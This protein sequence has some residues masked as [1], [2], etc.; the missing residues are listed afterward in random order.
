MRYSL[1]SG[2]ILLL[3]A[4]PAA[5]SAVEQP[6]HEP[7]RLILQEIRVAEGGELERTILR[8]IPLDPGAAIDPDVLVLTRETLE[9]SPV[10]RNVELYTERGD[11]PGAVILHVDA[12]LERRVHFETGLGRELMQGWY[13][14]TIGARYTNPFDRGGHAR[15][16]F[17]QFQRTS[18]FFVEAEYPR[19]LGERCDLLLDSNIEIEHWT[20]ID[21]DRTL[22]QM[23]RRLNAQVGLRRWSRDDVTATLWLGVSSADPEE[24]LEDWNDEYVEPAGRLVPMP[25]GMEHYVDLRLDL[26]LDRIDPTRP[27][28][29]GHRAGLRIKA[30]D[31][32]DGKAFWGAGVE[33][34]VALPVSRTTAL[35]L[36]VRSEYA[37][38]GTPYHLR[39]VFG[40]VGS[41]RGFN[42]G[43]LSGPLGAQATWQLNTE[44]RQVLSGDDPRKPGITSTL[45][46]DVG[47]AWSADGDCFGVSASVGYGLLLRIPWIQV[48]NAE[49]AYPLTRNVTGD[50]VVLSMS[51]GRSF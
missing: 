49:V 36:Q 40:G 33:G 19:L 9:S 41:L 16:G 44:F 28:Q 26:S 42:Q 38:G 46:A 3:S 22:F 12:E 14:T 11:R 48:L 43:S 32:V 34:M 1:L 23:V 39:P 20:V 7:Y 37:G 21:G 2:L 15:M 27:W 5:I 31:I 6:P 30:S 29:N 10:L 8:L 24:D 47:D 35:A 45:F 51:L 25:S 50:A 18:G 17:R 4:A 13:L